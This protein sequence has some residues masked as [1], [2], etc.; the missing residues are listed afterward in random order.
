MDQQLQWV[1]C[2]GRDG[3]CSLTQ[4]C[5]TRGLPEYHYDYEKPVFLPPNS[6]KVYVEDPNDDTWRETLRSELKSTHPE[7]LNYLLLKVPRDP[8]DENK[9]YD[10]PVAIVKANLHVKPGGPPEVGNIID[11]LFQ[12]EE[13]IGGGAAG[14]TFKVRLVGIWKGFSEGHEFCLK[15]YNNDILKREVVEIATARRVREATIGGSQNHVNL[16]CVHDTSEFWVDGLPHYLVMDLIPGDVLE[17]FAAH[18]AVSSDCAQEILLGVARGLR[19]LHSQSVLHRDV[20]SANVIIRTDGRPVL[21]DLGVVRPATEATIT[22]SQAFLGTL[23]FA[24][25]EWLFAEECTTASDVYS[26][27]TIGYHLLTGCPIF[28]HVTLYSRLV[29]AV[30]NHQPPLVRDNWDAKKH[31][32]GNLVQRMLSKEP[33]QRPSLAEIEEALANKERVE[34][35]ICLWNGDFFRQL[36]EVYWEDGEDQ[37]AFMDALL[38]AAPYCELRDL[39]ALS[40]DAASVLQFKDVRKMINTTKFGP[41]IAEY[42]EQPIEVRLAW[43]KSRLKMISGDEETSLGH[44][45][46]ASF[47]LV[48]SICDAETDVALQ[49]SLAPL[50]RVQSAQ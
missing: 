43:V 48:N 10:D 18:N 29:E 22:D 35:W 17:D 36:P 34:T 42:F 11:N 28:A 2:V 41:T 1:A 30:R 14:T 24:A 16:V 46:E 37:R 6:I 4:V 20:K 49:R 19:A 12:V 50:L 39:L 26:L 15:W 13:H 38:A 3:N 45:I 9:L 32:L 25:P 44:K 47:Y 40:D 5:E 7:L 31:Y 27:G 21:L 8:F 23:R 33:Q